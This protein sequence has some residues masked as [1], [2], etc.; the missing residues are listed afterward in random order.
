MKHGQQFHATGIDA[1]NETFAADSCHISP[2]HDIPKVK[3]IVTREGTACTYIASRTS[4][5]GFGGFTA[6]AKS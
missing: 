1:V 6:A 4:G 2:T 5:L 3:Q